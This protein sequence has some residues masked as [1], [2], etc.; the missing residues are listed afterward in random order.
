MASVWLHPTGE[1]RDVTVAEP[2]RSLTGFLR[3]G[4]GQAYG[5]MSCMRHPV[6]L[7]RHGQ[8][9]WNVLRLTQGQTAHPRLTELGRAQAAAA[10]ELIAADLV[11]VGLAASRLVTSDL[12]RAMETADVIGS[13]LGLRAELDARLREQHLGRLE[14]RS[15]E[16]TW[17]VAET[18]DWSD[19]NTPIEGG[20]CLMAV[21]RR[22][23]DAVGSLHPTCVN[24]VV[25]HGDSIRTVI[26]HLTGS[27][28]NQA[29]WVEVPNGAVVRFDG[30]LTWL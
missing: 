13:R 18:L 10:A 8:S 20:E 23:A 12:A 24:V 30:E 26:A 2:P 17:A 22:M 5:R 11:R 27:A 9:E 4:H 25:S 14:G 21:Q 1:G 6:Y 19:P 29:P 16:E 15:Y 7:V 3:H 28:P